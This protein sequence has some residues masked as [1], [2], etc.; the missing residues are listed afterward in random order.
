[1]KILSKSLLDISIFQFYT[2]NVMRELDD[3]IFQ[4]RTCR[5]GKRFLL[6]QV[7]DV[8]ASIGGRINTKGG[9]L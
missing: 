9:P 1:M 7:R 8:D 3:R 4:F 2:H 5:A 6:S